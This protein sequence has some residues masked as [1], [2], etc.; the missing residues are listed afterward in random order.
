[1]SLYLCCDCGGSK[2][3]AVICDASG[4]VVG[5]GFSGPSNFAYLTLEAFIAAVRI[6]VSNA[7]QTCVTP[8]SVGPIHL[9]PSPALFAG[10]W[11]GVSGVD[12]PAA[13]AAITPAIASLLS[14]EE[15]ESK[16]IVANDTHLLAA[17][18]RLHPDVAY[19]V[20]VIGGTGSTVASFKDSNGKFEELGRVG[21]WGWILGDEGG[22]FHVGR[23]AVRQILI[24]H[25][26]A[27][28]M[29]A[30]P[31]ASVLK[32]RVLEAF[33]VKSVLEILAE[34]HVPDPSTTMANIPPHLTMPRE[35]RLSSLAP[36]VFKAAFEDHDALALD[37]LQTTSGLIA[38][39]IAILL[40]QSTPEA[41]RL[42]NP[43][44]AVISFG[45]SLVGKEEYRKMVLDHLAKRG[46]VFRYVEFVDDAAATGAIGLAVGSQS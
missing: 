14:M 37:V 33:S 44:E 2:T 5:R 16:L 45:G 28:V 9:P 19:V 27:S 10:A 1:M 34:V 29:A 39:E 13:I 17:P 41:P 4:Q 21:G 38:S 23:E 35:K 7:L 8:P 18:V 40:G 12:S 46:H 11:F 25:D 31:R 43:S 22:G 30:P 24:E 20:T 36:L 42:V 6:A 15:F 3:S 32:D 26:T